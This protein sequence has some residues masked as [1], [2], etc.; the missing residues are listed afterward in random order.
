MLVAHGSP[1]D[2]V[3]AAFRARGRAGEYGPGA[4]Y[5]P[6]AGSFS[7]APPTIARAYF[8]RCV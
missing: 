6:G 7:L 4:D 1:P 8:E 2:E 3:T 5:G